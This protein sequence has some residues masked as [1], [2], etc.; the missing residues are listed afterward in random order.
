MSYKGKF[1]TKIMKILFIFGVIMSLSPKKEKK[2][3]RGRL[4]RSYLTSVASISLVLALIGVMALFWANSGNL[5]GWVKENMAVSLILDDALWETDAMAM[6]DSLSKCPDISRS[7]YVSREQGEKELEGLLGSDFLSVFE[8]TPVPASIDVYFKGDSVS[9]EYLASFR[10]RMEE[11]GRVAE[12]SY[13][14]NLVQALNENLGRITLILTV[15][16]ALL[17]AISFALISNTVR[18]NVYARRFTIHTMRMVGA[19]K[20]F[21][22]RPFVRQFF[23]MGTVAG[24]LAAGVLAWGLHY[25]KTAG[26]LL[27]SLFDTRIVAVCLCGIVLAGMAICTV[28]AFFIVGRLAYSSK[29]KLYY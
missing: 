16:I 7:V 21:I 14:E 17:L 18:L 13:Q 2:P 27:Y 19:G 20:S 29:D 26:P 6:S 10:Q 11:D 3:F 8:A 1:D 15:M 12:V 4:V 22:R 5:T 25:L 9:Q 28:S 24:L 23:V